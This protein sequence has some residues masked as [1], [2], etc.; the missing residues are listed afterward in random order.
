MRYNVEKVHGRRLMKDFLDLPDRIY[1]RDPNYVAP[2]KSEVRRTLD[3]SKN[4]YFKG[5]E[6][7]L[8]VCYADGSPAARA[9]VIVQPRHEEKFG[10]RAAFFGFFECLNDNRAAKALFDAAAEFCK[11]KKAVVLE[12]PF[13]PNHYSELGLLVDNFDR[14]PVFFQTYNPSYYPAL[15]EQSGFRASASL[16][17]A[18]NDRVSEFVREHY[19]LKAPLPIP[20]GY[21]VRQPDMSQLSEEMETIR[22]IFNDAFDSNWHFL[23]ASREEYDFSVKFLN[24]ITD[25]SLISI[26]DYRGEPAA[27]LMFVLDVNPLVRQ[28]HGQMG[29]LKLV[30]FLRG[31]R[32]LKTVVLYA[33]GIR[34]RFQHS[35]VYPLMYQICGRIISGFDR[36]EG[37][38]IKQENRLARRS[39]ELL[40][41][42]EDKHFAIYARPIEGAAEGQHG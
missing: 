20:E 19:D 6:L 5:A 18:K 13:N 17:T 21:T 27:V 28:F 31:R 22:L 16:F 38:W 32:R 29:P 12:G 14:P 1:K 34:K 9:A 42:K 25:P 7:Q 41:M 36:V 35:R 23:A 2:L 26:I 4:P 37:T 39:G 15:L 3:A 30:R 40:G 24:L 8:F 10:V 33:G 11:E